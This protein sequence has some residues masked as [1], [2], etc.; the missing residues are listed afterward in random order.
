M[1]SLQIVWEA[2]AKY[3]HRDDR[4]SKDNV[5]NDNELEIR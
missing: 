4:D 5:R 1:R 3:G 2:S